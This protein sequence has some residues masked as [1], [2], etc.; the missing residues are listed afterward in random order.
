MPAKLEQAERKQEI[1]DFLVRME[2]EKPGSIRLKPNPYLTSAALNVLAQAGFKK[3]FVQRSRQFVIDSF[4]SDS[5]ACN[6]LLGD[7]ALIGPRDDQFGYPAWSGTGRFRGWL[8]AL[9][10]F[11]PNDAIL[12]AINISAAVL[13]CSI[14]CDKVFHELLE[15]PTEDVAAAISTTKAKRHAQASLRSTG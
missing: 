14:G 6:A 7:C 3:Q 13:S 10:D 4:L 1:A 9:P 15:P 2:R 8:S 11:R 12:F 5:A